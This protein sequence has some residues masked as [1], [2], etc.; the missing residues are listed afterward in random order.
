MV[1][2]GS[3]TQRVSS[4]PVNATGA[5]AARARER[6]AAWCSS[7]RWAPADDPPTGVHENDHRG[8]RD[9]ANQSSTNQA[10][11]ARGRPGGNARRPR[12]RRNEA[13]AEVG[14]PGS[15][16]G[17]CGVPV[18]ESALAP[19]GPIPNPVVTQRSAG[20]YCGG[21][22]TGGEAAADTPQ[23]RYGDIGRP[24]NDA[25]ATRGGAAAARWA[26]NPKVGGSNPPPAT[27]IRRP[28]GVHLLRGVLRMGDSGNIT[29][30]A[31]G[32]TPEWRQRRPQHPA[33][34]LRTD[35]SGSES[36]SLH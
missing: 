2:G 36:R 10:C 18:A 30:R 16:N 15:P 5:G 14:A 7:E 27:R 29:A 9:L 33:R 8:S 4:R 26:H 34:S 21:D 24:A 1:E 22:P 11:R 31:R 32:H 20:E 25:R 28:G 13:C 6:S 3:P 35:R 17:G 23:P 19:P 12:C